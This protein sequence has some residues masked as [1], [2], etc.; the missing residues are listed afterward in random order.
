MLQYCF[1][2]E[3]GYLKEFLFHNTTPSNKKYGIIL[4]LESE[5]RMNTENLYSNL[6]SFREIFS[7]GNETTVH[8]NVHKPSKSYQNINKIS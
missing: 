4:N 5:V 2:L 6:S 7:K 3:P 1:H 8:N